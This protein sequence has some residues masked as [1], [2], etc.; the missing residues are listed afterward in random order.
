MMSILISNYE[1]EVENEYYQELQTC[2]EFAI[3]DSLTNSSVIHHRS[4]LN[5]YYDNSYCTRYNI[6]DQQNALAEQERNNL[7]VPQYWDSFEQYWGNVYEGLL[8][9]TSDRLTHV[10]DSLKFIGQ[11]DNL[12]SL[13]F[14]DMVVSFIQDMPYSFIM[15]EDCSNAGDTPCEPD[16]QFGILSPI[17]FLYTLKGDCDTRTT[18]LYKFLKHFGYDVKVVVS[19]EYAH[20]MLAINL[21][22]SGDYITHRNQRY[23][24]WE[25]TNI[26]WQ[27]GMLSGDMKNTTYWKIALN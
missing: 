10:Q 24:F 18:I 17:E 21:P 7:V 14:A 3:R 15:L 1:E 22:V 25:T 4:W 13:E 26:G 12:N 8:A 19:S 9:S 27:P 23:Y 20:A 2:E 16:Q 6:T 11:R 5:T